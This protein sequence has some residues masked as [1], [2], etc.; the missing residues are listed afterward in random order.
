MINKIKKLPAKFHTAD[1]WEE[2]VFISLDILEE[3]IKNEIQSEYTRWAIAM[4][5]RITEKEWWEESRDFYLQEFFRKK[6]KN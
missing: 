4:L 3:F 1:D 6:W 5:D 2:Y